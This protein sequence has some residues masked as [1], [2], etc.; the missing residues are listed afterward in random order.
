MPHQSTSVQALVMTGSEYTVKKKNMKE[1][2]MVPVPDQFSSR[3]EDKDCGI[4]I[5][6][7]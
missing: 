2:G 7:F 5:G 4:P 1:I 6:H 3:F